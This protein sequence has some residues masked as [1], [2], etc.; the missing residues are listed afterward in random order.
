MCR[1]FLRGVRPCGELVLGLP[2]PAPGKGDHNG[3][4]GGLGVQL[5]EVRLQSC[6]QVPL[7]LFLACFLAGEMGK[8]DSG[9]ASFAKF[10]GGRRNDNSGL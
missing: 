5:S 7:G 2:L 1:E 8:G 3:E 4:S 6:Q 9:P 10:S